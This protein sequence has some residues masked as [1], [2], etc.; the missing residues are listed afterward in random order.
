MRRVEIASREFVADKSRF[1]DYF[2]EDG[3]DPDGG[4]HGLKLNLRS[5]R[6]EVRKYVDMRSVSIVPASG[7]T[8]TRYRVPGVGQ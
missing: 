5:R 7:G 8:S 6:F 3:G 4:V 2:L 1:T